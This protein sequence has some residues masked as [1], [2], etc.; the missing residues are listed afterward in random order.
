MHSQ[1]LV[2]DIVVHPDPIMFTLCHR[3][4]RTRQ[5]PIDDSTQSGRTVGRDDGLIHPENEIGLPCQAGSGQRAEQNEQER[6]CRE[7]CESEHSCAREVER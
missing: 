4:Q 6:L 5:G 3:Q 2:G 1:V 7:H